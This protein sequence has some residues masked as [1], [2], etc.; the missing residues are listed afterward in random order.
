M[1]CG[2]TNGRRPRAAWVNHTPL[3]W[4]WARTLRVKPTGPGRDRQAHRFVIFREGLDG[5]ARHFRWHNQISKA[6]DRTL[7]GIATQLRVMVA[8][9]ERLGGELVGYKPRI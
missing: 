6:A 2:E 8:H 7:H 5:S 1:R 9:S 4:S 3:E